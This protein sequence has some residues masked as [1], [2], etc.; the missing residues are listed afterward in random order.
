MLTAYRATG[1]G[2]VLC[3]LLILS[4]GAEVDAKST[5]LAEVHVWAHEQGRDQTTPNCHPIQVVLTPDLFGEQPRD[6]MFATINEGF[7]PARFQLTD[8]TDYRL[9]VRCTVSMEGAE[10]CGWFYE[11]GP[12]HLAGGADKAIKHHLRME[13]QCQSPF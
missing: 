8:E 11:T 10:W 9:T 5:G 3:C 1:L 12:L 13:P 2:A 4:T 6:R 7:G